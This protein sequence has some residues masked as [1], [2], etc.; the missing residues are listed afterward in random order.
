MTSTNASRKVPARRSSSSS[1]SRSSSTRRRS[2][3]SCAGADHP[4]RL[5]RRVPE[6]PTDAVGGVDG[7]VRP[8]HTELMTERRA[9]GEGVV[10][11]GL[12]RS[13]VVG[14]DG[15]HVPLEGGGPLLGN[16][17]MLREDGL[18]PQQV[19]G[20]DV[21]IPEAGPRR[22]EDEL[23]AFVPALDVVGHGR[24]GR[25][26]LDHPV[27]RR[28]DRR[29][30]GGDAGSRKGVEPEPREVERRE[31]ERRGVRRGARSDEDEQVPQ[32][33]DDGRRQPAREPA[34]PGRD[35]H[36]SEQ[37]D[38]AGVAA[39]HRVRHGLEQE[40]RDADARTDRGAAISSRVQAA[41]L[42]DFE[43]RSA[44]RGSNAPRRSS[45]DAGGLGQARLPWVAATSL[46]GDIVAVDTASSVPSVPCARRKPWGNAAPVH[47][48]YPIR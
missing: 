17:A 24:D 31:L 48:R 27:T 25:E 13:P 9:L 16:Q 22:G 43:P 10:E 32:A 2:V 18:R 30:E 46:Q 19:T 14:M 35:H 37:D 5:A 12:E 3:M 1:R 28:A 33:A 40:G 39:D 44:E 42:R 34:D 7:S 23:E 26:R 20:A 29:D 15:L 47:D 6:H 21:P 11:G 8:D 41:P 38:E 4:D 45:L 36:G